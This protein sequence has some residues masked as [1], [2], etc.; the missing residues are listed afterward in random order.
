MKLSLT[1]KEYNEIE[2]IQDKYG[3]EMFEYCLNNNKIIKYKETKPNKKKERKDKV[4]INS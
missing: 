1:D 2:N 3:K 4:W